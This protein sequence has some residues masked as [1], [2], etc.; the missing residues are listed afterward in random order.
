MKYRIG[1]DLGGTH[2]GVGLVEES[3]R[4]LNTYTCDTPKNR[5][6]TETVE[7]IVRAVETLLRQNGKR[8]ED[9]L[10]VGVG[11]PGVADAQTGKIYYSANFGWVDVPLG[12]EIARRIGLPTVV[13]NDADAAGFAEYRLGAGRGT[14]SCV[15]VTLGTGVGGGIVLNGRLFSGG[16]PGGGELGHVSL[17]AG[18]RRCQCGK[19]GC[20]E[21]YCS[22]TALGQIAQEGLAQHPESSLN[23]ADVVD[24]KAVAD[25]AKA[26]DAYAGA[27]FADYVHHL[28]H[29]L[30]G[31]INLLAPEVIALGGGVSKA[32]EFLLEPLRA[33]TARLV[34]NKMLPHARIVSA[35]MGTDAGI[36][37]A[38]LLGA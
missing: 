19:Q 24:A 6:F 5:D 32:G 18:G 35:Q 28:A 17:V 36:V 11:S 37:G 31:I 30:A 7:A 9:C 38:A 20:A 12:E 33:E 3:G 26:G 16:M 14:Q 25:A 8:I 34:L 2:I 10:S 15:T 13:A 21:A 1:V 23:R 4:L 29:L 27:V 22:A